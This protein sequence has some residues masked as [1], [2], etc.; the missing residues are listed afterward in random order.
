MSRILTSVEVY[1]GPSQYDGT[2]IVAILTG[3]NPSRPSRN[4]KTGPMAQLWILSADVAPSI[5]RK[6]GHDA[7]ICGGCL[8]RYSLA[9]KG[10]PK[11][12][13]Q[14]KTPG[15]VWASWRRGNVPAMDP[16][17]ASTYMGAR[18]MSLR[19]GAYGDPAAL[20]G[21]VVRGLLTHVS[22]WTGYTH[23]WRSRPDL[24]DIV[25]AST[26]AA[27]DA[28]A[29]AAGW[30]TFSVTRPGDTMPA[31]SIPCP[32]DRGIQCADCRLCAGA[33]KV[34]KSIHIK[35]HGPTRPRSL[36]VIRS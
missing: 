20:P 3:L 12:Y 26:S 29:K 17:S 8:Y 35:D 18:G 32:S 22:K 1:R 4:A 2:P 36:P 24:R 34:A 15:Q 23:G 31:A 5:A 7:G 13:V 11:C 33:S 28:E 14:I 27:D 10:A 19:L 16:I 21:S 30:R 9:P 6:T 25:M